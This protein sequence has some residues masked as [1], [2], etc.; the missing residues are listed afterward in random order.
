M[1]RKLVTGL[2][3][4]LT[5]V[6]AKK[7]LADVVVKT[8][9]TDGTN[10]I[11]ELVAD[12]ETIYTLEVKANTMQHPGTN[13]IS[14]DFNITLPD[15]VTVTGAELPDPN[16][17]ASGPSTNPDDFYYPQGDFDGIMNASFN[18]VSPGP[19]PFV[20]PGNLTSNYRLIANGPEGPTNCDDKLLGRYF[21]K[22]NADTIP[23]VGNFDI[24]DCQF[25]DN[26]FTTY[27]TPDIGSG[28]GVTVQNQVYGVVAPEVFGD[29]DGDGSLTPN[30]IY[31]FTKILLGEETNPDMMYRADLNGD[32]LNDGRD[33][34]YLVN[35]FTE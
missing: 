6:A 1:G 22:V 29:V 23:G 33:T 9:V 32:G 8:Q 20:G 4:L 25:T 34:Q 5:A 18:H 26:A 27:D 11:T 2:M 30:D 7:G 28:Q 13:F 21:F 12:G 3:A 10:P 31:T 19:Y 24:N 16:A 35:A 14:S 15:Y 17:P